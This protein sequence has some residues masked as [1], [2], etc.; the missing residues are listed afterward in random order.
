MMGE[1]NAATGW[2]WGDLPPRSSR[3]D[4]LGARVTKGV[5]PEQVPLTMVRSHV[6]VQFFIILGSNLPPA[7]SGPHGTLF[8]CKAF[9][10]F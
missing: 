7:L 3:M 4:H 9:T 8:L 1:G 6:V 5:E 2:D 10:H